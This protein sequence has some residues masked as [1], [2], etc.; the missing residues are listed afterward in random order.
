MFARHNMLRCQGVKSE[1]LDSVAQLSQ[2]IESVSTGRR[3]RDR[4]VGHARNRFPGS[5]RDLVGGFQN[6]AGDTRIPRKRDARAGP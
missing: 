2:S 4:T 1:N 5:G 3:N 6:V